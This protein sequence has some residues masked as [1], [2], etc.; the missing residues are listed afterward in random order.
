MGKMEGGGRL[1]QF[2]WGFSAEGRLACSSQMAEDQA[3]PT[4]RVAARVSNWQSSPGRGLSPRAPVQPDAPGMLTNERGV[5][6]AKED[7]QFRL[8]KGLRFHCTL[9]FYLV[10]QTKNW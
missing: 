4:G 3:A 2:A 9:V 10:G 5:Q 6:Q 8:N 7:K 1:W